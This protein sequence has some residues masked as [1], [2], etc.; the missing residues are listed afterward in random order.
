MP[1]KP[2]RRT[3]PPGSGAP[4]R[5]TTEE[6]PSANGGEPVTLAWSLAELPSTQHRAGLAGL[7][8]LVDFTRRHPL[9]DGAVLEVVHLD[10]TAFSMRLNASGL[11]AVFDRAYAAALE[12]TAR[13][14]PWMRKLKDGSKTTE[15]PPKRREPRT[16]T[17]KEGEQT[18]TEVC[19]YDVV[20]PDG[21]PLREL[22]PLGDDGRWMG[23]W[24]S[25]V[26]NTL[27]AIPKQRTP[28]NSRAVAQ[29][30][31]DDEDAEADPEEAKDVSLAWESLNGDN[32][33]KLASTYYLGAM[34]VNAEGVSFRDR[35]RFLFLLHFW[36]FAVHV[37]VPR[38]VDAKGKTEKDGFVVCIPEVTQL[39]GF[40]RRYQRACKQRSPDSDRIWSDTPSQAT[41][42]LADAAAL[43]AER[44]LEGEV[45]K[46]VQQDDARAT[47]GFQVIHTSREGNTVR[48]RSNHLVAPS[49]EQ[50]DRARIVIECWSHLAKHQVLRNVLANRPWWHGFERACATTPQALTVHDKAFRHDARVLFDHFHPE[51]RMTDTANELS[52]APR[53]LESL[54][55]H[56][57]QNWIA[58]RLD[59]KYGLR[60]NEVK[61]QSGREPEYVEKRA[62]LAT[63]AFLA[64][65]S[66]P[67]RE[68]ARWFTATLCS[69]NQRLTEAEF[70]AVARA[71]DASPDHVRS[72]TLLALSARG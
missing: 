34:D 38:T 59:G 32:S 43:E 15:V 16:V 12:E 42:D 20:V 19:I 65:R 56:I 26:W 49:R 60:W 33:A 63:E 72:L 53:P 58:G 55:L 66:R 36:P 29:S 41:I 54:V 40:V 17:G 28:Y 4:G 7:V 45:G 71:L 8:M 70:V 5:V 9:P 14:K 23:L 22:A 10:D 24:R 30:V 37:F 67:G 50:V 61:G 2:K 39:A 44:W 35:G 25:W 3:R 18:T 69:V 62:K 57:V 46:A 6:R 68:F 27:R 1:K 31:V 11:A 48:L 47:A 21:G 52:K 64:A 51:N 13:A